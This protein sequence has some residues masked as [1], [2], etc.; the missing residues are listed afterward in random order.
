MVIAETAAAIA[1]VKG[2]V[3]GVK[4]VIDTCKDI[5]EVSHHLD[6]LFKG[7]DQVKLKHQQQTKT[8]KPEGKWQAY[9][10]ARFG[11]QEPEPDGTSGARSPKVLRHTLRYSATSSS[12]AVRTISL[13]WCSRVL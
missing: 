11:D 7:H 10:K 1:L 8:K 6:D 5:S 2:S 4:A 3:E 12:I 13:F 9:I